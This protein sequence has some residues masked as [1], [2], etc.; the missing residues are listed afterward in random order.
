MD[1]PC[2][3]AALNRQQPD[4]RLS[5]AAFRSKPE[6][7]SDIKSLIDLKNLKVV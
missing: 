5:A 1:Y 3:L 6:K 2:V 7:M 4:G